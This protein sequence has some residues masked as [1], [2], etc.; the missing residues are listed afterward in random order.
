[1]RQCSRR[2]DVSEGS[3]GSNVLD[4]LSWQVLPHLIDSVGAS[5]MVSIAI[6]ICDIRL[7]TLGTYGSGLFP[8]EM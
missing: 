8:E 5:N 2:S 3:G 6:V 4:G 7:H 1:M